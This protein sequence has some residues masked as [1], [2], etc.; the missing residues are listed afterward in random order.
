MH[1]STLLEVLSQDV[2]QDSGQLSDI[3]DDQVVVEWEVIHV[4]F[5]HEST[6]F[7]PNRRF[8]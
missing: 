4:S 7:V 2:R 3:L 5:E 8:Y 6:V 1:K